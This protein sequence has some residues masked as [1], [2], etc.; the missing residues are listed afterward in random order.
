MRKVALVAM[1]AVVTVTAGCGK[2]PIICVMFEDKFLDE[3]RI[4]DLTYT[5][6]TKAENIPDEIPDIGCIY[7]RNGFEIKIYENPAL[8]GDWE[9]LRQDHPRA[10]LTDTNTHTVFYTNTLNFHPDAPARTQ[11][12]SGKKK[13]RLFYS[14]EIRPRTDE[15][16]RPDEPGKT[17]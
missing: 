16:L 4:I 15:P 1:L 10:E 13:L 2:R 7:V 8:E 6:E 12:P 5:S 14:Y 17:K 11:P 9:I 3:A